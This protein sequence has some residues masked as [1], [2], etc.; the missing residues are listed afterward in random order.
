MCVF[1]LICVSFESPVSADPNNQ[2]YFSCRIQTYLKS[3]RPII[4][5]YEKLGKVRTVDASRC[6][7]EVSKWHR[8]QENTRPP[9]VKP[10]S[11]SKQALNETLEGGLPPADSFCNLK[12]YSL[13]P[14]YTDMNTKV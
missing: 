2:A 14:F 6:V 8:L 10:V 7:D 4:D 1:D 9:P 13:R 3:T 11:Q 5:Q 12:K